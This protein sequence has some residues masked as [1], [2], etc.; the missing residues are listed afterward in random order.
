M[1]NVF[2][3]FSISFHISFDADGP[4]S[5]QISK[6]MKIVTK[7][8]P[9]QIMYWFSQLDNQLYMMT[10]IIIFVL[11]DQKITLFIVLYCHEVID[12]LWLLFWYIFRVKIVD[13]EKILISYSYWKLSKV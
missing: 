12:T 6:E 10:L 5:Y 4:V 3:S 1:L 7:N 13:T 2:L 9:D 11:I 8:T